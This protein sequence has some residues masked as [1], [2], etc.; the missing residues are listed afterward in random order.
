MTPRAA[1]NAAAFVRPTNARRTPSM[2]KASR[3]ATVKSRLGLH[4]RPAMQLTAL[5]QR[6]SGEIHIR[7]PDGPSANGKNIL[8][9]MILA[10]AFGD[11]LLVEVE[12]PRAEEALNEVCALIEMEFDPAE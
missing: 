10:A 8:D 5:C 7:K 1:R 6:F 12:D 11:A 3:Q 9:I 4:A 2:P